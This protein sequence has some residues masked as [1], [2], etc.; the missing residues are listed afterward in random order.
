MEWKDLINHLPERPRDGMRAWVREHFT[1]SELGGE[2]TV[3]YRDSVYILGGDLQQVVTADDLARMEQSSG[4]HHAARCT[5]TACGEQYI[6]GWERR[7]GKRYAIRIR[8]GDDGLT[9]DGYIAPD[10]EDFDIISYNEDD[11]FDCPYCNKATKLIHKSRLRHGRTYQLLITSVECVEN[12]GMLVTWLARRQIDENGGTMLTITPREALA[13]DGKRKLH[14]YSHTAFGC[15]PAS[16]RPREQWEARTD[17]GKDLSLRGYYDYGSISNKKVG[18]AVWKD[19]PDVTGTTIEKTGLAEYVTGC[20]YDIYPFAY[21]RYWIKHP[22]IENLVKS[23]WRSV[24]DSEI[25]DAVNIKNDDYRNMRYTVGD[26]D[27]LYLDEAKPHKMLGM[28]KEDYKY[29]LPWSWN[30]LY[31]WQQYNDYIGEMSVPEFQQ[32]LAYL[33]L[34]GVSYCNEKTLEGY[35]YLELRE[36]AR[37]ISKQEDLHGDPP[38][39]ILQT[40]DDYRYMLYSTADGRITQEQWF[41]RDLQ[42][43]H[44]RLLEARQLKESAEKREAFAAVTEKYKY[45]E[46]TDGEL[47][48]ILPTCEQDLIDEGNTL[49]H[50]VGGYGGQYCRE[51][52]VIFFIRHHRRPERSYYTLDIRFDSGKPKR[53]QLHGYGNEHHGKHKEHKHTIPQKVLDFVQKWETEILLPRWEAQRIKE[54]TEGAKQDGTRNTDAA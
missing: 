31:E 4:Y 19:M 39:M 17:T 11:R 6:A 33:G 38:E 26:S 16:E 49:R 7:H 53:V 45:L 27:V 46:Y 25:E 44:D 34:E 12:V 1:D 50:C 2:Y 47:C 30:D 24:L 52:D 54:K 32:I 18:A 48:A 41:P 21:L 35:E 5:C 10:E 14:A 15:F 42:A 40:L 36:T 29:G 13:L 8:T 22:T 37:Y 28:R 9:Y 43:A 23:P 51:H 3:F 20:G